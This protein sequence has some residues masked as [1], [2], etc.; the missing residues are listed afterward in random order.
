MARLTS[1]PEKA[2]IARKVFCS[3]D[4][5]VQDENASGEE[6]SRARL[7]HFIGIF[8]A[9]LSWWYSL[10]NPEPNF[11]IGSAILLGAALF[12]L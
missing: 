12:L 4:S 9:F 7:L 3:E 2:S 10:V 1:D 5:K 8:L 11:W 6:A